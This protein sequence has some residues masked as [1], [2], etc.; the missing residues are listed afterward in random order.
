MAFWSSNSA[1]PLRRYRF[2]ITGLLKEAW[3]VKS[4][5]LPSFEISSGQ[6]TILN[7]QAKIAGTLTWNDVTITTVANKSTVQSLYQIMKKN[8]QSLSP[9]E[10]SKGVVSVFSGDLKNK[11]LIETLDQDGKSVN[12]FEMMNWFIS[13]INF[14]DL[15]YSDDELLTIEV[16]IAYEYANIK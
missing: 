14:G 2:K 9:P 11:I 12:K 15:D 8:G 13:S 10:D 6:Y 5:N 4:A 7:H 3:L 1:I 16:T